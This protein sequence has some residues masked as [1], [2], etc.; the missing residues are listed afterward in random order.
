VISGVD[1]LSRKHAF[2]R[3]FLMLKS[4]LLFTFFPALFPSVAKQ[5]VFFVSAQETVDFFLT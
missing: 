3:L 5:A 2:T 4:A 1:K